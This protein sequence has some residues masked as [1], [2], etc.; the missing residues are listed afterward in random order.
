MTLKRV[1]CLSV[2]G[3]ILPLAAGFAA[4]PLTPPAPEFTASSVWL[5]S[6]PLTL[7]GLRDKKIVLVAFL[8]GYNIN[9]LRTLK[10]LK[11]LAERYAGGLQ[12]IGVH[13]PDYDFQKEPQAVKA[14]LAA[15]KIDFPVVMDGDKRLWKAYSVEGWPSFFLIDH[16]GLIV[17]ERL[18]EAA[19][20]DLEDQVRDELDKLPRYEVPAAQE[21][22]AEPETTDCG[23][24]TPELQLGSRRAAQAIP[25]TVEANR[26][27]FREGVKDGNW[28]L[29]G[30]W[31]QEPERLRLAKGNKMR[32]SF[33]SALYRGVRVYSL[34]SPG[35]KPVRVMLR[36]DDEWLP[37]AR[38]GK[39]V[40]FDEDLHSYVDVAAT[41]VYSLIK[42]ETDEQHEISLIPLQEG[43][44]I[45]NLSFSDRCL[46]PFAP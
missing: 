40:K 6:P 31:T 19:Y 3:L 32:R 17:E 13:S 18:G 23:T 44:A 30:D 15:W 22:V 36:Q 26:L 41:R 39:D 43:A 24:M 14:A 29:A 46:A 9:S 7:K 35:K 27:A 1:L 28:G 45:Y 38:A 20:A 37:R 11:T 10:T 2:C 16:K 8:N 4:E 5:N 12:L 34:L 21:S 25:L 33:V 42:N